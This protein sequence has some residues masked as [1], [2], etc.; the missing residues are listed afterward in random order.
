MNRII[1]LI[2]ATLLVL[3]TSFGGVSAQETQP[4]PKTHPTIPTIQAGAKWHLLRRD[5]YIVDKPNDTSTALERHVTFN[6]STETFELDKI[7]EV[8][9][10]SYFDIGKYQFR[11]NLYVRED[12]DKGKIYLRCNFRDPNKVDGQPAEV[13]LFD[14]NY[15]VGDT[16][17]VYSG[18][19]NDERLSLDY[20]QGALGWMRP[21]LLRV[22]NISTRE[23]LGANRI[24][25]TLERVLVKGDKLRSSLEVYQWIEGIGYSF[26]F[27]FNKEELGVVPG[28]T[29]LD[30]TPLCYT[31]PAGDVYKFHPSELCEIKQTRGT[32]APLT[33]E[34]LDVQIVRDQLGLTVHVNDDKH[35]DLTIYRSDGTTLVGT[36]SFYE[37]YTLALPSNA[38]EKVLVVVDD[39]TIPYIL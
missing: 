26:G 18:Y 16:V 32:A 37:S 35:H 25:Y 36:T 11:E 17:R 3:L 30:Y 27:L 28:F 2:T 8:D 9:G 14:Y 33:S 19:D 10:K 23:M 13:V 21:F 29:Y 24:V 6:A 31:S 12:L 22:I 38:G 5:I 15:K 20:E 39:E 7:K 1:N 4:T 34:S